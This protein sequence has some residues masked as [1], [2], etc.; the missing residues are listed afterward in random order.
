MRK[1]T[2]NI[3]SSTFTQVRDKIAEILL[4]E[5]QGQLYDNFIEE[6]DMV[7]VFNADNK[8]FV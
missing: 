2:K 8:I 4:I 6:E 3:S 7:E 1:L 5:F